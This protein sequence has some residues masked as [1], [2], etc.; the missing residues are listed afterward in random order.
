MNKI[1]GFTF[2]FLSLTV[3]LDLDGKETATTQLPVNYI[4][5][6]HCERPVVSETTND[7]PAPKRP[8]E[9]NISFD[10]G[11]ELQAKEFFHARCTLCHGKGGSGTGLM[12]KV[13]TDPPP[14]DLTSSTID[15][16]S[17][18]NIIMQGGKSVGRSPQMPPWSDELSEKQLNSLVDYIFTLRK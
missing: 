5:S 16:Q 15:R 3:A 1:Y 8:D 6:N 2:S 7:K 10:N 14:Y 9:K 11:L 4:A 12:A 17:T 13:I 18:I